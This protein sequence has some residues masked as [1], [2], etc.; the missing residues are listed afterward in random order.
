MQLH[1]WT[2]VSLHGGTEIKRGGIYDGSVHQMVIPSDISVCV[3]IYTID[4]H[5]RY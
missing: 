5:I 2:F 4:V 1:I 3:C